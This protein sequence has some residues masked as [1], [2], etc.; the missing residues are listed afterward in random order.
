[1]DIKDKTSENGYSSSAELDYYCSLVNSYLLIEAIYGLHRCQRKSY[2]KLIE[3]EY[4]LRKN[5]FS[6][7]ISTG[8]LVL[9]GI[10]IILALLGISRYIFI[11]IIALL[12][13]T[14]AIIGIYLSVQ[15]LRLHEAEK[16]EKSSDAYLRLVDDAWEY[17]AEYSL[18]KNARRR[19]ELAR[20]ENSMTKEFYDEKIPRIDDLIQS[21]LE[22]AKTTIEE[23]I[24]RIEQMELNPKKYNYILQKVDKD[25]YRKR[26]EKLQKNLDEFKRK[27]D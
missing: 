9:T 2:N 6:A 22:V 21:R 24:S 26:L 4:D 19:L 20:K 14:F 7:F 13:L 11:L 8:S 23:V 5:V 15:K 25:R 16:E 17:E 27:G 18:L 1:M 3:I 10:G 12:V